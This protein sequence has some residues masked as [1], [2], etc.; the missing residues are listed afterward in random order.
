MAILMQKAFNTLG[1]ISAIL[2]NAWKI[3]KIFFIC[4][5]PKW[6]FFHCF[7]FGWAIKTEKLCDEYSYPLE[8]ND[9]L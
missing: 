6:D 5:R 9:F 7:N 4:V 1:F 3:L 2:Y 8:S